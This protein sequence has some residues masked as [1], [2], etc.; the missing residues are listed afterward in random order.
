MTRSLGIL[1]LEECEK[2][3]TFEILRSP[4]LV[5][6]PPIHDRARRFPVL[7]NV[8]FNQIEYFTRTQ[9]PILTP[10]FSVFLH[11]KPSPSLAIYAR[12]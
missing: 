10:A 7:E 11:W 4:I 2:D 5:C 9:N 8:L 1:T 3:P 6:L 12:F